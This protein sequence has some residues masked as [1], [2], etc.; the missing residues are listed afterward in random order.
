MRSSAYRFEHKSNSWDVTEN[1]KPFH[2]VNSIF[3]LI[4]NIQIF[5]FSL[6]LR[7]FG[8]AYAHLD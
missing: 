4:L 3:Y 6:Y 5:F 1:I 2:E 8:P 7:G